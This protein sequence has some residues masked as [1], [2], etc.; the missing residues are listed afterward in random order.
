MD[1]PKTA[2][3]EDTF[4]PAF[5]EISRRSGVAKQF[6]DDG[7]T[8][9][10]RTKEAGGGTLPFSLPDQEI[11]LVSMGTAVL[12][13]RPLHAERPTLRI[14]GAFA[15]RAEAVEHA[16]VVAG[17]DPACSLVTIRRGEWILMPQDEIT[18]DDV[19]ENT[20]RCQEKL[21]VHRT[22]QLKM[23]DTFHRCVHEHGHA[24][25]S[26]RPSEADP[27]EKEDEEDAMRSVYQPP[28]RIR[29]GA[30]V[31]GHAAVALC[32]VQ[33]D[34]G[35]CIF[36]VLGCFES[37]SQADEWVRNIASRRITQD[38]VLVAPTCEWLY[39]NAASR[40]GKSHYRID[41]L[42]RIMDAADR[43]PEI[44][45]SYKEWKQQQDAKTSRNQI[46]DHGVSSLE[47]LD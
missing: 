21:N 16:S 46:G 25:T 9:F 6:V 7:A 3:I 15:T 29:A 18:R 43:N 12:S 40:G 44:V 17:I 47:E 8:Y 45:Q 36:K 27:E 31:R 24:E 37:T 34:L 35:E 22:R 2:S 4:R 20:R 38:D 26:V 33:D 41:E 13:P 39:P 28:R 19:D 11:V 32:V 42:Q 14:Y 10:E 23:A 30:E 5:E 1:V